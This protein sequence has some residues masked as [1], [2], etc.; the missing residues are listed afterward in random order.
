MIMLEEIRAQ[1]SATIDAV[2]ASAR[3]I[4][5]DIRSWTPGSPQS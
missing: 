5:E 2:H 3:E 1:N 4:R